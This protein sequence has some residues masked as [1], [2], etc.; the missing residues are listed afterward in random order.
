MVGF[1]APGHQSLSNP[2]TTDYFWVDS[3]TKSAAPLPTLPSDLNPPI[4]TSRAS[5]R[6][7][8]LGARDRPCLSRSRLSHQTSPS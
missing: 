2:E 4:T 6:G 3:G 8:R 5:V 1:V 7:E